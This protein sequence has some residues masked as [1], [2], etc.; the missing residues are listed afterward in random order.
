MFLFRKDRS[1]S[2]SAVVVAAAAVLLVAVQEGSNV[3]NGWVPEPRNRNR[4]RNN[5]SCSRSPDP[6][7]A[8]LATETTTLE[9]CLSPGCVADGADGVLLKLEALAASCNSD[10]NGNNI[11][12]TQGVCCS[13][14]SSGPVAREPSSGKKHRKLN[15]NKKILDLLSLDSKNLNP[16][17]EA[18]LEGIDLCLR[19]DQELQ[20]KK[21]K[22]ALQHYQ[23]GLGRGMNAAIALGSSGGDGD[24]DDKLN[25]TQFRASLQWVVK[26]LCSEATAKLQTR[27]A[28]GAVFSAGTAY[29]LSLNRS[30]ESLEVL[31]E[32]YQAIGDETKEREALEALFALYSAQEA[33]EASKPRARKKRK[34]P[35]E[36]NKRRTLG[37]RLSKLGGT[38]PA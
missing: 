7:T 36:A 9:V 35:M 11:A 28:D 1:I 18:V 34:N 22:Q 33:E 23:T 38:L 8:L 37:F 4:N 16:H 3:A 29:Q 24:D 13:L 15:S 5:N 10:T 12:V 6:P 19:G 25:D 20:R 31:Q 14:C 21:Y 26:A 27:D 2:V 32:A 17:Q 30:S